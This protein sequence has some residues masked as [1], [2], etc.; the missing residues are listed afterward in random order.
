VFDT[1][2]WRAAEIRARE[3]KLLGLMRDIWG[4]DIATMPGARS[5]DVA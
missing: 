4:I 3:A 1:S 2:V 5:N